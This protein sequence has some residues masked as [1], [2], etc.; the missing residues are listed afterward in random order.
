MS[1]QETSSQGR[2][3]GA[4][5]PVPTA[6][7][8]PVVVGV[9]GSARS[10][11]AVD[12]AAREAALRRHPLHVTHAYL[13]PYVA[14]PPGAVPVSRSDDAL[15]RDAER[16]VR[17]A[18]DRARSVAPS[19]G[20]TGEVD[21]GAP[22]P[23]LLE[24]SRTATLVVIGDRG[25]GGFTGLL[26]GSVAVELAAHAAS[27]VL[28]ARGSP[29]PTG[30]VLVGVDGSPAGEV[31]VAFAFAEAALRGSGLAALYA[32]TDPAWYDL[33]GMQ[34]VATDPTRL[35]AE[36]ER[37][38]AEPVARWHERYPEVPV[39][40]RLV[41]GRAPQA[42]IEASAGAQ[43]VVVGSR[44]R[45]GFTGLLLGSVSQALLHHAACPVAVVRAG[46]ARRA[47]E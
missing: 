5:T 29:E 37:V 32:W 43:L 14:V 4:G 38:L 21:V 18:V 2:T 23:A 20:I 31:A 47:A 26:V 33:S 8:G 40:F 35:E 10:L 42:L 22:V 39:R 11:D 30:D 28:V 44:G 7:T 13:W 41:R 19:V 6:A 24:R 25:L 17:E 1:P 36:A 27:P 9:D 16:V 12:V 45:G 15:R 34:F 3:A 46:L